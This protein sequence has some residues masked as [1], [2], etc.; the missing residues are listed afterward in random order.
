MKELFCPSK[1]VSCSLPTDEG[2]FVFHVWYSDSGREPV[3]LST[4][5]LDPNVPV[6]IR[7]HSECLTGDI[8]HSCNCDC[9][10]QKSMA[11]KIIQESGNGIFLYDRQEGR[12][13]GLY[14]KM[15]ALNLQKQGLDTYTANEELGF[16]SDER[17]YD[18]SIKIL[19]QFNIHDIIVITN[20]PQKIK[21]LNDAGFNI[22]ERI[23]VQKNFDEHN[24]KYLSEKIKLG[25][26]IFE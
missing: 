26:H 3:A 2:W 4:V 9:G 19:K 8:F 16:K 10:F 1:F 7:I 17:N 15:K 14:E 24:E 21:A 23:G 11:L 13:I 6:V 20:N 22:V 5:T 25:N 18:V 12:G